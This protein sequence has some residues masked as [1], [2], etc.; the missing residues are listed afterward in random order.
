MPSKLTTYAS[1]I[2]KYEQELK[3]IEKNLS[4]DGKRLIVLTESLAGELRSIA[5][6]VLAQ[7]TQDIEKN[8]NDKIS[9]LTKKYAEEREKELSKIN[10]MGQ[11]NL[12]KASQ[13]VLEKVE[14]VF[15]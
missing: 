14:E 5:D 7:I 2:I 6:E 13:F 15:K 10:Q 9:E 12:E 4:D 1:L 11:K 3:N 8:T